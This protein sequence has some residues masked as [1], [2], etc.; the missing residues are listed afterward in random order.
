[1]PATR[2]LVDTGALVA[3]FDARDGHHR[4]VTD[5]WR[6]IR[7][8][9]ETIWPVLTE[10]FHLL[11]FSTTACGAIFDL[12]ESGAMVLAPLDCHDAPRIREL[13]AKYAD[14]PIDLADA[15]LVRVAERERIRTVFTVD[16]RGFGVFAP[17]HVRRFSLWPHG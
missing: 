1:V 10:A 3:L 4:R 15:C 8:P 14:L 5:V 11:A 7:Q 6:G 2:V 13:M 17:R 12:V 16:R 9:V